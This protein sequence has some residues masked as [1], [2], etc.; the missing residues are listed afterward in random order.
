MHGFQQFCHQ[1]L[2]IR[3]DTS[4]YY[5]VMILTLYVVANAIHTVVG[6][7]ICIH[8]IVPM[9]DFSHSSEPQGGQLLLIVSV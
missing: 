6:L 5:S 9:H 7:A 1:Q 4:L 8:C 3:K 2:K